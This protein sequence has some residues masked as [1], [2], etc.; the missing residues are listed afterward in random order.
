[1]DSLGGFYDP[2]TS[3]PRPASPVTSST[4]LAT[5]AKTTADEAASIAPVTVTSSIEGDLKS[6]VSG[7]GSFWGK[8]RKQGTAALANAEA[9]YSKAQKDLTP[10]LSQAQ[11]KLD[12]L[13]AQTK[14]ELAR[15]AETPQGQSA[16]I[17][18][19]ADGVPIVM[20][21]PQ[22]V[23]VDKGKGVDRGEGGEGEG[24][25]GE[26]QH[27]AST[28]QTP[29]AAAAAFFA[30]LS[31]SAA[32]QLQAFSNDLSSLRSGLTSNVAQLQAQLG[33][34][35]VG[36]E[37]QHAEHLA[38]GYLQ[39]GEAWLGEFQKEVGKLAKD[40]VRVVPPSTSAATTAG[41]RSAGDAV[42][43][44][45]GISRHE[46]LLYKLRT[47]PS[48]LLLDP[49]LP[50][51]D[52]ARDTREAYAAFISTLQSTLDGFGRPLWEEKTAAELAEGGEG[53]AAVYKEL[54][55]GEEGQDGALG[56]MAFWGR[57]FFRK[58]EI[59]EEEVR[60]KRVLEGVA[61]APSDDDFSW[62]MDDE[63]ES[64]VTS[65]PAS[66]APV[67][68]SA[69][70]A[71]TSA[72]PPAQVQEKEPSPRA[73]SDTTTASAEGSY[74]LVGQKS[75]NPSEG[76]VSEEEGEEV[77]ADATPQQAAVVKDK[78]KEEDSEDSDWE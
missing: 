37:I 10:F 73:S 51:A 17:V 47:G 76:E 50:P 56:E 54:V 60:R 20:D 72:S 34:L 18:I 75:G 58:Q 63:T 4:P 13:S 14:A 57:Y 68:S 40:A 36:E 3:T 42:A 38:Q 41:D 8:V 66:T 33:K 31:A 15:L 62:D 61:A 11:A 27:A 26:A 30:S 9:Q 53:F 39:K 24:A 74:D 71:L 67:S 59:E 77:K 7:F 1:M 29:A 43:P 22:P 55:V 23:K 49:A 12:T 6:V 16:G 21:E 35:K 70:P 69:P 65:P 25:F 19:G 45:R 64:S 78:G 52:G 44:T 32:P 2:T 28:D 48:L 46:L 5:S